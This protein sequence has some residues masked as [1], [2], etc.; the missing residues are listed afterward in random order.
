MAT[1]GLHAAESD[2]KQQGAVQA[3][4]NAQSGVSATAA[5]KVIIDEARKAGAA[6]YQFDPNATAE[7]KAAQAKAVSYDIDEVGSFAQVC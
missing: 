3:A 7:E 2:L 1:A 4:Q 5:E 6:A